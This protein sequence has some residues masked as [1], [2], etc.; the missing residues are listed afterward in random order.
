MK[1][2][3]IEDIIKQLEACER[4][5][6]YLSTLPEASPEIKQRLKEETLK[7]EDKKCLSRERNWL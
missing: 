1:Q 3:K 2:A 6:D 7:M 4:I 5:N